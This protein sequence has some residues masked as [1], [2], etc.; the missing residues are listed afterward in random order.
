MPLC[1]FIAIVIV[2]KALIILLEYVDPFRSQRDGNI[3]KY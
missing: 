3:N 2:T 1:N